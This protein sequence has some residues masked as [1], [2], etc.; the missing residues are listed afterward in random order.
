MNLQ[1]RGHIDKMLVSE[2]VVLV[3]ETMNV[4]KPL[5]K[6]PVHL[7]DKFS[8]PGNLAHISIERLHGL[9][10]TEWCNQEEC[11]PPTRYSLDALT[12]PKIFST[13]NLMSSDACARQGL[14]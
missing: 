11:L 1:Q 13:L 9:L 2:K 14:K 6:Q 12:G 10:E 7:L 5:R 3:L 8:S 4:T